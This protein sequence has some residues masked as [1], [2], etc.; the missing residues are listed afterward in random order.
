MISVKNLSKKYDNTEALKGISFSINKGEIYGLL[1]PNGAGKTTTISILSTLTKKD[2][3]EISINGLDLI[4]D[5]QKVKKNIG[6]VP[7]EIT[8]N[9]ELSVYENLI[10]LGSFHNLPSSVLEEKINEALKFIGLYESKDN[11]IKNCSIGIMRR[12]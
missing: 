9:K 4:K 1:G 3:G 7:Q 10:L 6:V 12:I 5:S 11:K 2:S 8:L